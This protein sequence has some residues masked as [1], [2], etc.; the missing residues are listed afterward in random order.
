MTREKIIKLLNSPKASREQL[1]EALAAYAGVEYSPQKEKKESLFNQCKT[2]F[3]EAY[4]QHVKV[5]Y[6][7]DRRDGV[8]LASLIEKVQALDDNDVLV[9]FGALMS[10]LPDWYKINGF[11]LTVINGK[12]NEIV[13]SIR[14]ERKQGITDNYKARIINDLTT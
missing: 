9:T 1:R 4:K 14:N 2:I 11:S 13:A 12:F 10:N 3:L 7:F 5:D 8:A 6:T